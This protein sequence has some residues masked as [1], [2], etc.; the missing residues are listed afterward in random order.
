[1]LLVVTL[2]APLATAE[3]SARGTREPDTAWD[4]E[5]QRMWLDPDTTPDTNTQRVYFNVFPTLGSTHLNPNLAL[6]G[7]SILPAPVNFWAILGTWKDCN[8]DGYVGMREGALQE[9]RAEL[10]PADNPCPSNPPRDPREL[11]PS[12]NDGLWV[13]ELHWIGPGSQN[14]GKIRDDGARVWGD[15]GLPD[16]RAAPICPLAP[17]PPNTTRSTGGLLRSADCLFAGRFV[18]II[19]KAAFAAGQ[20]HLGFGDAPPGRPDQSASPLN[21]KN[22][23]GDASGAPLVT[24]FDCSTP[25]GEVTGGE[26]PHLGYAPNPS[27]DPSGSPAG[28]VNHT[29]EAMPALGGDC[30]RTRGPGEL[31]NLYSNI[32]GSPPPANL[33]RTQSDMRFIFEESSPGGTRATNDILGGSIDTGPIDPILGASRPGD[34]GLGPFATLTGTFAW[35]A[36]PGFAATRN[37]FLSTQSAL[38]KPVTNATF[39]AHVPSAASHGIQLPN[40]NPGVYGSYHCDGPTPKTG[41]WNCNPAAW[42][43]AAGAETPVV[44]DAYGLL[45]VDCY[46]ER[47]WSGQPVTWGNVTD[48]ACR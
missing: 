38:L 1:M 21:Q 41:N 45:D 27:I 18:A 37:P 24:V 4:I 20:S 16:E 46:D 35:R 42:P 6:T 23:Y 12:H 47:L 43:R 39:Y 29:L 14:P 15:W 30:D 19:N 32:E 11:S 25:L 22:P 9:Y 28:T 26:P 3:W 34:L 8:G 7:S 36:E 31:S 13:R 5:A 44:A 2:L 10:L 40:P 48:T 17:P 33:R